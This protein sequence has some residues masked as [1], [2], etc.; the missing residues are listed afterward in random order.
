MRSTTVSPSTIPNVHAIIHRSSI[1][2]VKKNA[3]ELFSDIPEALENT[4]EIAKRRNVT[5]RLRIF[6]AAV[7]DHDGDHR[8][9]SGQKAK[10]GWKSVRLSCFRTKKSAK[11]RPEYDERLDIELQ[12]IN[13]M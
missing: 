6:P 5:V 1:C 10:E 3:C 4:V 12:V 11:R 7:P 8:R 2:A 13:Q 9:L